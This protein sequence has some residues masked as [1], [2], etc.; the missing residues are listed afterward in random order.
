MS[1]MNKEKKFCPLM[2]RDGAI[3]ECCPERCMFCFNN[4]C[5]GM[6]P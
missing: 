3:V 1:D 4:R 5:R 6:Q 2:S